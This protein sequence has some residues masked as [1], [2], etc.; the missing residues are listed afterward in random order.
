MADK[1]ILV[2]TSILIDYFR[3]SDKSNSK[4][5]SLIREG[6][7]FQVSSVTEYEIFAGSTPGQQKYWKEFLEKIK[8]L[9]FDQDAVKAAVEINSKLKL[10]SKQIAIADLFIAATAISNDLPFATLNRKHFDR[11]DG[12][13]II[14]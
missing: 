11:I 4:L 10:K 12:L 8:V 6:Y 13:L 5:I 2:D 14:S 7:K 1:I 9:P 3:K